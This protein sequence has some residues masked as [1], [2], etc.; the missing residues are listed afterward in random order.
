MA[1]ALRKGKRET[2]YVKPDPA[3]A[4]EYTSMSITEAVAG[5]TMRS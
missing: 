3:G 4:L 1:D 5:G 2:R